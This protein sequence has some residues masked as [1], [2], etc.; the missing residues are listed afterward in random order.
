MATPAGFE[1]ATCG[2]EVRCSIQ[3][4]YGAGRDMMASLAP[5]TTPFK[6]RATWQLSE[7]IRISLD[8]S[9]G[10]VFAGYAVG[11]AMTVGVGYGLVLR[12][13]FQA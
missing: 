10:R 3:L 9:T 2:L 8:A 1:P 5:S 7:V 11:N 12:G 6:R 4:S 13:E